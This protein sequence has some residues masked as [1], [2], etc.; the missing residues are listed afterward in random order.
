MAQKNVTIKLDERE[1][2][3]LKNDFGQISTAIQLIVEPFN[4]LKKTTL[5]EIK[6]YFSREELTVLVDCLNGTMLTPDFIYNKSFFIFNL[7]DF[8]QLEGGISRHNASPEILLNKLKELNSSTVYFLFLEIL[9]FWQKGDNL[10][11]FLERL[12]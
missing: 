11:D 7:E 4:R 10:D 6:G 8:E 12:S 5:N 9:N 2:E 1:I 3:V